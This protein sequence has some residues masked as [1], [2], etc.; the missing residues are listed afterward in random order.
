MKVKI[1]TCICFNGNCAE[2]LAFYEKAFGAKA[3][4]AGLY[5]DN[6]A[7]NEEE[8]G[9]T[10]QDSK[11]A[12]YIMHASMKLDE[13]QEL[14]FADFPDAPPFNGSMSISLSFDNIEKAKQVFKHL[15]QD[16]KVVHEIGKVFWSECF[17]NVADKFGVDW[18]ITVL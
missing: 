11:Y 16:G 6:P 2:A 8:R 5:K 1:N 9:G 3:E 18:M 4:I 14:H 12:D 17:G 15:S 7:T 10:P 13:G